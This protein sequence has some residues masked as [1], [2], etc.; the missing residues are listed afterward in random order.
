M[1]ETI[2]YASGRNGNSPMMTFPHN[3]S[4]ALVRW[5]LIAFSLLPWISENFQIISTTASD[6]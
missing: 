5:L 3:F 2:F 4:P 1:E 6:H